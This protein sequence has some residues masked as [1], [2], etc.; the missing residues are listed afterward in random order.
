[1][2]A[3][4]L[5]RV[6]RIFVEALDL[7]AGQR[8]GFLARAC[9]GDEALRAEVESLLAHSRAA[10]PEFMHVPHEGLGVCSAETLDVGETAR[11]TSGDAG[12]GAAVEIEGYEIVR[13]LSRGGQGVVYEAIQESP[14]RTVA[15][16]VLLDGARASRALRR[17][18]KRE[19][20][21]VA[22]LRHPNIIS[23][24]HSG[25]T[26]D[27]A[28]F[29]VMDYVSGQPLDR[30][31]RM[32]RLNLR[33]TLALL[34][35]VCDAVQYAHQKGVI[36]RDLKP[37]N[38]L[39]DDEGVPRILDF[40]LAKPLQTPSETR[41]SISREIIGTLPYMA[42]EQIGGE[43]EAIDIRTDVYALG[44]ICYLLLTGRHPYPVDGPITDVLRHI[45][46]S[47]PSPPSRAWLRGTG[48]APRAGGRLR[49]DCPIDNEVETI[50]L[51]ALAKERQRRYQSAGELARDIRRYL[52]GQPIE[53]K[54][55]SPAYVLWK[56]ARRAFRQTPVAALVILVALLTP[57]LLVAL[58]FWHQAVR[59]RDTARAAIHF[60]NDDV[61]GSL[62]PERSGR[63]VDLSNILDAAAARIEDRFAD[64]PLAEATIRHTLGNFYCSLGENDEALGQLER[65]MV[66]TKSVLGE[67]DPA[68]ADLHI[69]LS[70]V[71]ENLGR[72]EQA[73]QH[74]RVAL[75]IR[76][77]MLGRDAPRT[78]ETISLLADFAERQGNLELAAILRGRIGTTGGSAPTA[79]IDTL[80][81]RLEDARRRRGEHH[82]E[83]AVRLGE[84]ADALVAAGRLDE[85]L[86]LYEQ[87]LAIWTEQLGPDHPRACETFAKLEEVA[88]RQG[89]P[90][91]VE[92]I[93]RDRLRRALASGDNPR[94]L[95]R[96]AWDVAK[97]P[98]Y[99]PELYT[100]AIEAARRACTLRPENGA[101]LNTLGVAQVR[102]G[103]YAEAVATLARS[104]RLNDGHP[105]DLAFLTVAYTHLGRA[106]DARRAFA[107]LQA[108]VRQRPWATDRQ[109]Q[110]FFREASA[111]MGSDRGA[112]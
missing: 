98:H 96:A 55:D 73:E 97:N 104:D 92:A 77:D 6:E 93:V 32:C 15:I 108:L 58:S 61:F 59:Q 34:A 102:A 1:M 14:R 65:A 86:P 5:E 99:P 84:L 87:A 41:L 107:R 72:D 38:I 66:L 48:V 100:Q 27:G 19:I 74:L 70:R 95:A 63:D 3:D 94:F 78:R 25:T 7:P 81:H 2:N 28:R 22:Q 67:R 16:K 56:Q 57:G 53:A 18:F 4:R 45:C 76:T 110:R 44:V 23:I 33:Q 30:Y 80:R 60:L 112:R 37:T 109:S 26:R 10:G 111:L 54:A 50:V 101:F 82:P 51:K 13:E 17:R 71:M 91:R 52:A 29:Y 105:A 79:S 46:D 40:G 49:G 31:V 36:H 88:E 90:E 35:T 64:A 89:T 62:D 85:A 68:V 9:G 21:L 69:S 39:V 11:P 8:E 106:D 42:P 103:R 83:V 75:A 12:A 47:A 24:F 20:E 43:V